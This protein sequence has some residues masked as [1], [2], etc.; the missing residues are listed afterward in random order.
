VIPNL[1]DNFDYYDIISGRCILNQGDT[2]VYNKATQTFDTDMTYDCSIEGP[3]NALILELTIN[4]H[5]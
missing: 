5:Y 4:A 1:T 3:N 2:P